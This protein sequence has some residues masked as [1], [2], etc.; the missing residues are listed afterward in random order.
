MPGGVFPVRHLD[1][2][3]LGRIHRKFIGAC[4]VAAAGGSALL[5]SAE[6]TPPSLTPRS[7]FWG[8]GLASTYSQPRP[9]IE[10]Q[11]LSRLYGRGEAE[12]EGEAE[13][14]GEAV[15]DAVG[16]GEA[17]RDG[18]GIRWVVS[19]VVSGPLEGMGVVAVTGSVCLLVVRGGSYGPLSATDNVIPTTA[20]ASVTTGVSATTSGTRTNGR[21]RPSRTY[22][23]STATPASTAATSHHGCP[24]IGATY[25]PNTLRHQ[26]SS[27]PL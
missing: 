23:N 9:L 24:N 1:S 19:S 14:D 18:E 5:D 15:G 17:V 21:T 25:P 8:R 16:E 13:G 10:L 20:A 7:L 22:H 12:G 4:Y 26:G 11:P 27:A 6:Q 3:V 2:P